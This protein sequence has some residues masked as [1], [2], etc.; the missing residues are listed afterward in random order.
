MEDEHWNEVEEKRPDLDLFFIALQGSQN[1][2]VADEESDIDS[3][4]LIVPSLRELALNKPPISRTFIMNNNE[5]CD[6]K[7]AREYLKIVLK[8]NINFVEV[9]FTEWTIVNPR[10]CPY[11]NDFIT[12]REAI[13][14][15]NPYQAV[16]AMRGMAYQKYHALTHNYPS[17]MEYINKYGFDPKQLSHLARIDYFIKKYTSNYPYAECIKIK[18]NDVMQNILCLKRNKKMYNLKQAQVLAD[19]YIHHIDNMADTFCYYHKSVNCT[20]TVIMME[21]ILYH[22]IKEKVTKNDNLFNR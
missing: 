16:K 20:R 14:R 12:M 19:Y 3:K 2:G 1:Y 21:E 17:R 15:V 4:A 9:F 8:C 5:H 11:W 6:V 22:L 7:D 18:D 13:A 10:Y